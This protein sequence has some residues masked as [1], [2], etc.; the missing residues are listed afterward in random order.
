[1]KLR[2]PF[3]LSLWAFSAF[4][5]SPSLAANMYGVF[6]VSKGSVKIQTADQKTSDAKVGSKVYEGDT[7]VTGVDSRAKIVMSDRNV[8]NV[9]PDT[10]L[11][12]AQYQNNADSGKKNVELELVKGKV[13]NNVEQKYEGENSFQVKTPT[14]V[15]GV[16]GTQFVVGYNASSRVTSVVTFKGSVSLSSMS[17]GRIVGE[18]VLVNKGQTTN[19]SPDKAPDAPTVMPKGE[20]KKVDSE[21]TAMKE[22]PANRDVASERKSLVTE[23]PP[24]PP[25][26]P[27]PPSPPPPPPPP[28]IVKDIVRDTAGKTKVIVRP[29][30]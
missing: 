19:V 18:P 10:Q 8:I 14:A 17:G 27:G 29:T 25:K 11:K 9:S 15:A 7:I 6:M 4:V 13:R 28:S 30:Q 23:V 5:S 22:T 2:A 26:P 20:A 12:I 24:P 1:M 21:T 16:R 3:L